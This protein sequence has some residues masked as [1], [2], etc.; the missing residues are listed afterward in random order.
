[1]TYVLVVCKPSNDGQVFP[2]PREDSPVIHDHS[3]NSP[4]V[5]DSPAACLVSVIFQPIVQLSAIFLWIV[6]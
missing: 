4:V 6:Q 1:M 3:V 2:E 5:P